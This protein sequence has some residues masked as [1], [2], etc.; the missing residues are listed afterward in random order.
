[1]ARLIQW[2]LMSLDGSFEG[3]KSWDIDWFRPYFNSE[4]EKFS[5]EQ[6][7]Q[8]DALLFGRVTYEGMAAYWKTAKGEVAEYM[9]NLPKYVFSQTMQ[10][11]DWTNTKLI[12]GDPSSAVRDIKEK[13]TRDLYV[14]GSGKLCATLFAEALFDEV[15][16]ALI[17]IV[18]GSGTTLFGRDL[19]K[20]KM[21]LLESRPLSNGCVILRY[22]PLTAAL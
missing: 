12:A 4:L 6:L 9:N 18:I 2:N 15:R 21:K 5:I 8:A 10:Q 22:E 11:A 7:R 20:T 14:F 19:R 17:P 3:A 13:C 1:M 16:L